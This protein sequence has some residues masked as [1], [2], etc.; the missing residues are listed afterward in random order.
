MMLNE[1]NENL[2]ENE[3]RK[4]SFRSVRT[5]WLIFAFVMLFNPNIQLIDILPDFIGYFIL[6]KFFEKAA[7]AAPYFEEAR[8]SFVRLAYINLFKLPALILVR[9]VRSGNTLDN[10][11][12][13]LMAL[14]FAAIEI[15]YI[16][17]AIKNIFDALTYL[18]E[19]TEAKSLLASGSLVSTE[20]LKSFTFVFAIFKC[21]LYSIPEFLKLTR[22]VDSGTGTSF[23]TGSRYYPFAVLA[24][25][26]LGF[27][28]G[29]IWLSRVVRLVKKIKNEGKYYEA[30]GS[31]ASVGAYEEYEK[32]AR[33]RAR[34]RVFLYFVL[35]SLF[36]FNLTFSNFN[37]INLF[38]SF[39][40][41]I[42]FSSGLVGLLSHVTNK[43]NMR[44]YVLAAS[45]LYNVTAFIGYVISFK[46]LDTYGYK[47]LLDN[48][49]PEA[50]SA[51]KTVEIFAAIEVIL[52]ISLMVLFFIIMKKYL[53][54]NL[55]K[56]TCQKR[57]TECITYDASPEQISQKFKNEYLKQINLRTVIYSV[58]GILVGI[59]SFAEVIING[60]VKLIFSNPS[61]VTM[62]TII[63]PSLPWFSL[64]LTAMTIAYAFYSV[65]YFNMLKEELT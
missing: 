24:S 18:G 23:I 46:F 50:H 65:Y 21:M 17:P 51:Y 36:S 3:S 31:I 59:L 40:F 64:L 57:N 5:G 33:Q 13:A 30:L 1:R 39:I 41:G 25:L 14:V 44:N 54:E 32:K 37:D 43:G 53:E 34:N 38:P 47:A 15:I 22:S 6:A 42:L 12:V 4:A 63:A 7:D 11:I 2:S 27:I 60:N 28:F 62:P 19:R 9:I 29:G 8:A 58:I 35:A 55:G 61:D 20:A 56:C 49:V 48:T 26:V 10:D 52:Y 16:I 45:V